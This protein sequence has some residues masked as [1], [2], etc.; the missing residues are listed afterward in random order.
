MISNKLYARSTHID[1][2]ESSA[3]LA[4]RAE[5]CVANSPLLD[6]E[7]ELTDGTALLSEDVLWAGGADHDLRAGW[8]RTDLN[9]SV[10][11][12]SQLAGEELKGNRERE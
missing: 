5:R 10:A 3:A 9:T 4:L 8:G 1:I 7:G 12:L 2:I 6:E 11:S